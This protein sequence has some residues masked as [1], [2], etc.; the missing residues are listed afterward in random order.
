MIAEFVRKNRLAII[1]VVVGIVLLLPGLFYT[2]TNA[3]G[4]PVTLAVFLRFLR[5]QPEVW[6]QNP[7]G[8]VRRLAQ[9]LFF[10]GLPG[11]LLIALGGLPL[12]SGLA[13]RQHAH[14]VTRMKEEIEVKPWLPAPAEPAPGQ[15]AGEK[16]QPV[17]ENLWRP[18][19]FSPAAEGNRLPAQQEHPPG[20]R[21][22]MAGP[23]VSGVERAPEAPAGRNSPFRSRLPAY[24]TYTGISPE[25]Q[26]GL[27][28]AAG[29]IQPAHRRERQAKLCPLC[30]MKLRRAHRNWWMRIWHKGQR[31]YR[32]TNSSCGWQGFLS[33]SHV[34]ARS[35]ES[36]AAV[37]AQDAGPA[38][39]ENQ[40]AQQP[41]VLDLSPERP[42]P[43]CGKRLR[44]VHR[45]KFMRLFYKGQ[46]LYRCSDSQC[47][48][49]GLLPVATLSDLS[50]RR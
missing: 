21:K 31:R 29:E 24:P 9:L 14:D 20:E 48:W 35:L 1:L 45:S 16:A 38:L 32:C 42:C 46:R 25:E 41:P 50:P 28:S 4:A 6:G 13:R 39:D 18:A 12:L 22:D 15:P 19:P 40:P 49:Q 3:Q 26:A 37:P 11:W 47:G 36:E 30:G 5:N 43:R 34:S 2:P 7:V 23:A 17:T 33:P 10:S 27:V 44:R 8:I